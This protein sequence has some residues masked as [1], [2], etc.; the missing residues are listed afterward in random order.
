[1]GSPIPSVIL[2]LFI[3]ELE[4]EAMK[5][6]EQKRIGRRSWDRYIDRFLVIKESNVKSFLEHLSEHE[7]NI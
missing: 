4:N 7:P 3:E 2:N 6:T 5:I 1:M